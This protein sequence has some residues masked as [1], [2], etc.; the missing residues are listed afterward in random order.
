MLKDLE[1][2]ATNSMNKKIFSKLL[3][4]SMLASSVLA[5]LLIS[6]CQTV[7][8]IDDRRRQ[9]MLEAIAV[10]PPG[11]YFI[12]RRY[13]KKDYKFWGFVRKPGE[14]WDMAKMVMLN[15]HTRLA[16]DRQQ[17]KLGMDN[18]YEYKLYGEFSGDTV[19]E[20]ASNRFFPEFVLFDYDLVTTDPGPIFRT[21]A[22]LDPA[23]RVIA[24]PF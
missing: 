4:S 19:Y 18:G 6:A 2:Q 8:S 3:H 5:L 22:A 23:R 11:D 24:E 12:G 9:A 21:K 15:E 7:P 20:P 16:P 14:M 17:G 1:D 13:Y 10:E